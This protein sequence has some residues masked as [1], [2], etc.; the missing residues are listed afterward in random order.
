MYLSF[1]PTNNPL[2]FLLQILGSWK[3]ISWGLQWA[4][5]Y[6]PTPTAYPCDYNKVKEHNL[7]FQKSLSSLLV[8][9]WKFV[10]SI[11]FIIIDF[12]GRFGVILKCDSK[13]WYSWQIAMLN[14]LN[15]FPWPSCSSGPKSYS[16]QIAMLICHYRL[17]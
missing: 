1:I 16:W 11:N 6:R 4:C 8:Y 13:S 14:A 10:C 17:S 3:K 5:P 15:Y 2:F 7:N 12:C 9:F